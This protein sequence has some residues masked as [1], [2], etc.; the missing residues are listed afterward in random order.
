M[1]VRRAVPRLA[2]LPHPWQL[3]RLV[4]S[5]RASGGAASPGRQGSRGLP[6]SPAPDSGAGRWPA[7]FLQGPGLLS[8]EAVGSRSGAG[9]ERR[10]V[11]CTSVRPPRWAPEH[12]NTWTWTQPKSGTGPLAVGVW[13]RIVS[14]RGAVL[15]I[16]WGITESLGLPT[17]S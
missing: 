1:R 13:S 8:G 16:I 5:A 2:M 4:D 10:D 6:P 3:V 15:S 9:A 11:H 17:R 14:R 12:G 7:A